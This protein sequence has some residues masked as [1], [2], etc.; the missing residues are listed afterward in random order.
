M[1]GATVGARVNYVRARTAQV[2]AGP[3]PAE[4]Y[5]YFKRYEPEPKPLPP[6][7]GE[8][9]IMLSHEQAKKIADFYRNSMFGVLKNKFVKREI[10]DWKDLLKYSKRALTN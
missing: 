7:L 6:Y 8:N 5:N 4:K 9:D 3:I 1:R 2:S 10:A